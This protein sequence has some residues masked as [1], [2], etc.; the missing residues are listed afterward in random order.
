MRW[1]GRAARG[2]L[3]DEYCRMT[4]LH[5]KAAIRRLR[6]RPRSGTGRPRGRP[7]RYGPEYA[8]LVQQLWE[9]SDRPCGK[10]LAAAVPMLLAAVARHRALRLSPSQQA[11][12]RAMSPATLD[13]RLR[14]GRAGR[15][16]SPRSGRAAPVGLKAEVPIRPWGE[17]RGAP[18]STVQAD[19]VLHCGESTAGFYLSTLVAVDVATGWVDLE[20]VWGMSQIHVRSAVAHLLQRMPV[21]VQHWHTDNDVAF[22]NAPRLDYCRRHG[23]TVSRGRGYHK[24]DQAYVEQR[25]WLAVRRLVGRDRY[26][27]RAAFQLLH[28]LY[29]LLRVQLN[30]LRPLRKR[31]ATRRL[32]ARRRT[33][34][35]RPAA[36]S[37]R[38]LAAHLLP[39]AP[40][41]ALAR[42]WLTTNPATLARQIQT[43]LDRLW[44]TADRPTDRGAPALG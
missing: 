23:I 17:W 42:Q 38:V 1:A 33:P 44:A 12:L 2:Q 37:A 14:P 36:P 25:N 15:V 30:F 34:Y 20:P 26:A 39:P 32:G 29:A 6:G 19:L 43:T 27:A 5:R 13:R 40:R 31:L 9:W 41:A 3:L 11:A 7:R 10:L 21:R 22:L 8:P 28:Q 18:P 24:N 16:T 4:G 35:D